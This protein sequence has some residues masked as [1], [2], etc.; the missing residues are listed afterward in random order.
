[1]LGWLISLFTLIYSAVN[2]VFYI[3][4]LI[5]ETMSSLLEMYDFVDDTADI[6]FSNFPVPIKGISI[7]FL[8]VVVLK[9][10]IEVI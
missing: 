1:M 3:V 10:I 8:S 6:Y 4:S 2:F 5:P 7:I 9:I